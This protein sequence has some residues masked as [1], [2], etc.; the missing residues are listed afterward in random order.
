MTNKKYKLLTDDDGDIKSLYAKI[1][2]QRKLIESA[3]K[4]NDFITSSREELITTLELQLSVLQLKLELLVLKRD[5]ASIKYST[6][7]PV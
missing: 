7:N 3:E 4:G 1:A 6:F 5:V 2:Y